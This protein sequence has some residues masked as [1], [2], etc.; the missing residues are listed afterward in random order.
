MLVFNSEMHLV[1]FVFILLELM[2]L[3]VQFYHYC[4]APQDKSRLWYLILLALLISYN[5]T[6]G[7]FPDSGMPISLRLQNT[8][9]YG[10]GF[11]MSAYFPYY[12]YKSFNL[13]HLRFQALYGTTVFLLVPYF[14]FFVL[15]YSFNND[16]DFAINYGLIIPFIYSLYLLWAILDAIRGKFKAKM[17]SDLPVAKMEMLSVYAAVSP[18]VC[19]FVFA[20][21]KISQWI[22][23]LVTNVGFILVTIFFLKRSIDRNRCAYEKQEESKY[24][25]KYG[26]SKK[27]ADYQLSA[28]EREIAMLLSQGFTYAQTGQMLFISTKTVDAHIRNIF[29]KTSSR[30]KIELLRVLGLG[31][32]ISS[33]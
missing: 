19:L 23:V 22:E 9:A 5:L 11:L 24:V 32:L 33:S 17:E 7:L 20:Y 26:F 29:I 8:V 3:A 15:I 1:T 28:R 4:S 21:F 2:M 10:S 16:L 12:F 31:Q 14:V 6:G 27:C 30:N 25:E 18:W 13:L